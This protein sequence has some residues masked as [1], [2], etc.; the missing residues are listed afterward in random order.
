[1][2]SDP[3]VRLDNQVTTT[4]LQSSD[5]GDAGE[6]LDPQAR[7]AYKRRLEELRDER[8]EAQTFN[9]VARIERLEQEMEF[10]TQELA[11][12]YGLG[13]RQRKAASAAQRA[14]VNVTLSIKNVLKKI[15]KQHRSL[16]LYFSTTIK[17][18]TF[19]SY[20]PDPRLPVNWEF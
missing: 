3:E 11:S 12:A 6:M 14:R 8:N 10:L 16:A 1:V 19:C 4:G 5:L 9:D 17:T 15:D 13:G 20:T 18:G 7:A 2:K